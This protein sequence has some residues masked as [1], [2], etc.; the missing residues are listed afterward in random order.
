VVD[1]SG[2]RVVISLPDGSTASE[3]DGADFDQDGT[4]VTFTPV[5]ATVVVVAGGGSVAF[6][7][8]VEGLLAGQPTGCAI[9]DRP[10]AS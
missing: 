4:V 1:V 3:A 8:V 10:C 6:T 5:G 9:D 2:W 7:L